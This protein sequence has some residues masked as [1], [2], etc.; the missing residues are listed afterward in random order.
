MGETPEDQP[1]DTRFSSEWPA[2]QD[3]PSPEAPTPGSPT[4]AA[5]ARAPGGADSD[6]LSPIFP[7]LPPVPASKPPVA[8]DRPGG[9]D[10]QPDAPASSAH[11][12]RGGLSAMLNA[13]TDQMPVTRE[14]PHIQLPALPDAETTLL[15]PAHPVSEAETTQ[16]PPTHHMTEAETTRLASGLSAL[17]TETTRLRPRP[18]A[19][20][21]ETT[22]LRPRSPALDDE[23]TTHLT[24]RPPGRET[25]AQ[26]EWGTEALDAET[27]RLA[28]GQNA[29]DAETARLARR[30][31][32]GMG[33]DYSL[34]RTGAPF[35]SSPS[36][37]D[38]EA[39]QEEAFEALSL[40]R[41]APS[42][43]GMELPEP[44]TPDTP[45]MPGERARENASDDTLGM[46]EALRVGMGQP[47]PLRHRALALVSQPIVAIM[48]LFALAQIALL[49][50]FW[51]AS[52]L[53]DETDAITQGARVLRGG[54]LSSTYN[55]LSHLTGVSLWPAMT[56]AS[57]LIGGLIGVRVIAIICTT[58]AGLASAGAAK[59]LF[60][61]VAG[62]FTAIIFALSGPV[63]YFAHLAVPDQLAL[64][65]V[66]VSF[67]A[68]TQA[69]AARQ[70]EW[71]IVA[72]CAGAV[73]VIA[74]F[75]AALC[76]IPLLGVALALRG[77]ST[78]TGL[79]ITGMI[80]AAIVTSR[81]FPAP[82]S[83]LAL[84]P[85]RSRAGLSLSVSVSA[86]GMRILAIGALAWVMVIAG[87]IAARER[88][89]LAVTLV[90]G[91]LVWPVALALAN[92]TVDAERH[93]VFGLLFGLPLVGAAFATLW[94]SEER[95]GALR[96]GVAVALLLA[97]GA[98]GLIQARAFDTGSALGASHGVHVVWGKAD[99]GHSRL[100]LMAVAAD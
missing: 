32:P 74:Q 65:G 84:L 24:P 95:L 100:A 19:L 78:A 46:V 38:E 9:A 4:P 72:A 43:P 70:R 64:V 3:E 8:D 17:E 53:P 54:A 20:E 79:L 68:I 83:A 87:W 66:A 58:L 2:S 22:R 47:T 92:S 40:F 61:P 42:S 29:L 21:V 34:L 5:S 81:V 14:R 62:I 94:D 86:A 88:G 97:V 60:G 69:S 55:A 33:P 16:L 27:A 71:L 90:A 76:L 89:R 56:S 99:E 44:I 37:E 45:S 93:I 73:A 15:S 26:P 25:A 63:I 1:A 91:M 10:A 50:F 96:R 13:D 28:H 31:T 75:S 80:V 98:V 30:N 7:P 23:T 6:T 52:P 57:Y 82:E 39:L 11:V 41:S 49:T 48:A 85:G 59:N 51:Q 77:R 35:L 12:E 36:V 67:W 18:P